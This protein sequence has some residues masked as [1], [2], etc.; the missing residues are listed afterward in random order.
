[1]EDE[2][3]SSRFDKL[4]LKDK[5][6]QRESLV[7]SREKFMVSLRSKAKKQEARAKRRKVIATKSQSQFVAEMITK[8][9][10]DGILIEV[11]AV[12]QNLKDGNTESAK[13]MIMDINNFAK[14]IEINQDHNSPPKD[15]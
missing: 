5:E 15:L 2:R 12:H 10:R 11:Q 9:E 8:T 6:N 1:M 7:D 4:F 3:Q 14:E 13:Q